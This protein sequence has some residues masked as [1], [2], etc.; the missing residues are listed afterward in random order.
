MEIK[1]LIYGG[2]VLSLVAGAVEI[3][4]RL[5]R[6]SEREEVIQ[7]LER[8]LEDSRDAVEILSGSEIPAYTNANWKEYAEKI[9]QGSEGPSVTYFFNKHKIY[10]KLISKLE[11]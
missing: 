3:G 10:R 2:L 7:F 6:N 4:K 9:M 8:E 1:R 5:G 11:D